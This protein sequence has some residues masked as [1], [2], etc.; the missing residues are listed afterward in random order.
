MDPEADMRSDSP[1]LRI[2]CGAAMLVLALVSVLV[3]WPYL[4]E[5]PGLN[6]VGLGIMETMTVPLALMLMSGRAGRKKIRLTLTRSRWKI[7]T[8]IGAAAVFLPLTVL[9]LGS[10]RMLPVV[11]L[12]PLLVALW[13]ALILE[14]PRSSASVGRPTAEQIAA[15]KRLFIPLL[16]LGAGV[17]AVGIVLGLTAGTS[18]PL[19]LI[20]VGVAFLAVGIAPWMRSGK[21]F[22]ILVFSLGVVGVV[23]G[24]V[25]GLAVGAFYAPLLIPIGATFLVMGVAV[26]IAAAKQRK[27]HPATKPD[28]GIVPP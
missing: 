24:I 11:G 16:V 1:R 17:L 9:E 14:Q 23:G 10:P 4:R 27:N 18:D 28:T 25:L 13:L 20:P 21:E 2:L 15:S 7:Y 6:L 26:Q 3:T 8:L 22:L 5:A 12:G 19:I